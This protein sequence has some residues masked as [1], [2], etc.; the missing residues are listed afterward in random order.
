[1]KPSAACLLMLLAFFDLNAAI[2]LPANTNDVDERI[3][4]SKGSDSSESSP[5]VIKHQPNAPS[6]PGSMANSFSS[7]SNTKG[8]KGI[9][10]PPNRSFSHSPTK[11]EEVPAKKKVKPPPCPYP[12][13]RTC[14]TQKEVDQGWHDRPGCYNRNLFLLGFGR[15]HCW[16]A[17][18]DSNTVDK[19]ISSASN[20]HHQERAQ[21][22]PVSPPAWISRKIK[23]YCPFP[24]LEHV[25]CATQKEVDQ[26]WHDTD[27]CYYRDFMWIMFPI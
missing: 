25:R 24:K 14:I 10:L 7:H 17:G 11:R 9:S 22:T 6:N 20:V 5:A 26:G 12:E 27:G 13:T 19:Y 1:M 2:A 16:E 4:A 8:E 3:T 18:D 15:T 21:T 23:P